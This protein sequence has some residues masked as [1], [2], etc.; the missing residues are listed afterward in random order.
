MAAKIENKTLTMFRLMGMLAEGEEL[1]SKREDIQDELEIKEKTLYLYL[2]DIYRL[3]GNIVVTTKEKKSVE[4]GARP[5]IV[6]KVPSKERDV[7]K[8]LR[9]FMEH[10][11]DLSWLLQMLNEN[12][13]TLFKDPYA[14]EEFKERLKASIKEDEDVFLFVGTPFENLSEGSL[15]QHFT[16][17]KHATKEQ[18]YRT[19]TYSHRAKECTDIVKCLKLVFS[20]NNWYLASELEDG[21]FRFIRLS[22]V[23]NIDYVRDGSNRI[24]YRKSTLDK[25]R[26]FFDRLQNAMTLDVP[27]QKAM[28]EA[29]PA[30]AI[31]FDEGMKPF[32]PSQKF[33][34]KLED[35]SVRF[36]VEFTQPLE[37]LPFVKRWAP[38]LIVLSPKNL[39]EEM[40]QSMKK[41]WEAHRDEQ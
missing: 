28:L 12:D 29:T 11:D 21:D 25:Y 3:Y 10:S 39:R 32:F 19:I 26:E 20:D 14:S 18:E 37:I 8:V 15:K 9:Y 23:R 16:Q 35:G 41:A 1:Y 2:K 6:Y 5:I 33:V 27:V 40:A 22:F 30:V 31:Y 13:P 17:L 24:G 4:M 38:D 7:S 34:D 36:E